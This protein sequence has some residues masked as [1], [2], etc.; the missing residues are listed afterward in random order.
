MPVL[1]WFCTDTTPS[2]MEDFRVALL[3]RCQNVVSCKAQGIVHSYFSYCGSLSN[4]TSLKFPPNLIVIKDLVGVLQ[5]SI[6]HSHLPPSIRNVMTAIRA[7]EGWPG[8]GGL[9]EIDGT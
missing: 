9:V 1:H 6:N 5:N 3:I 2:S 8:R 7:H 4:L